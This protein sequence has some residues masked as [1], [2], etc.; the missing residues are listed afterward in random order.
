MA[1]GT[2]GPQAR[3]GEASGKSKG[4]GSLLLLLA[5]GPAH[6]GPGVSEGRHEMGKMG[7]FTW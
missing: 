4:A 7:G 1:G 5:Q 2:P 3:T 6:V